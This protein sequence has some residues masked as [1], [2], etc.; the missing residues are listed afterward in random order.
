MVENLLRCLRM[1]RHQQR[2]KLQGSVWRTL[3]LSDS[4]TSSRS[5]RLSTRGPL[6]MAPSFASNSSTVGTQSSLTS[7][8]MIVLINAGEIPIE[9]RSGCR[10]RSTSWGKNL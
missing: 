7:V 5:F 3:I 10:D 4:A 8:S 6:L 9:T 2:S 1:Y